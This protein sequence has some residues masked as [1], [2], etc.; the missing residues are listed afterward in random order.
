MSRIIYLEFL[1]SF[2]PATLRSVP[3]QVLTFNLH[4]H[5]IPIYLLGAAKMKKS[6]IEKNIQ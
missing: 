3:E 4:N 2:R 1:F 6:I 5:A